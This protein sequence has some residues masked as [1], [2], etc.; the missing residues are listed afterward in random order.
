MPSSPW[1][2]SPPDLIAR[3]DAALPGHPGLVRK[4][5]FGYPAAFVNGNLV[6]GLFQDSVV[7]RL[8]KDGAAAAIAA[9][10]ADPFSPMHGRVMSGYALVPEGDC[11]DRSALAPWLARAL[12]FTLTLP[13]KAARPRPAPRRRAPA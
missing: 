1:S 11:L 4:P 6:C 12:A 10:G 8:G 2:K 13:P 9:D 3:F 5:M 7:V